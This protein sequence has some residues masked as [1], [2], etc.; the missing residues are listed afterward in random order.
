[1][2]LQ[3]RAKATRDAILLGA[4]S[5]FEEVGY[6]NA[7]IS[8]VADRASVTKGA[9]YFHFPSK[10]AL[11]IAVISAQHALVTDAAAEI[12]AADNSALE[13]MIL[14]CG[15][16]ARQLVSDPI[17]RAGIRLT[18]EA[19]AFG[20]LVQEPYEDWIRSMSELAA[21][22]QLQGDLHPSLD[23]D[24]LA[25]YIVASFTGVQMVSEV[26]TDRA[27]VLERVHQMWDLLLP[28]IAPSLPRGKANLANLILED[29]LARRPSGRERR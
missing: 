7:S 24:K 3:D 26:L 8:Q 14:M 10:Q 23:T 16:F 29:P 19:A 21:L 12:T 28:S 6:G 4:A 22:A 2:V 27:D 20:H 13:S 25:R 15:S 18:L 11:A 17:V 9:L 5:V 1:M